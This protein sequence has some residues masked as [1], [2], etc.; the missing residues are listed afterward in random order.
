MKGYLTNNLNADKEFQL[1]LLQ[2]TMYKNVHAS[3]P[4][5]MLGNCIENQSNIKESVNPYGTHH[6][7]YICTA[8]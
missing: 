6:I 1:N 5:I 4:K 2:Q 3:V 8:V 7:Q